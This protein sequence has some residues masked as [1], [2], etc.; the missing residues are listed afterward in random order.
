MQSYQRSLTIRPEVGQ[1]RALR[2]SPTARNFAFLV[3]ASVVHSTSFFAS[4]IH[5]VVLFPN[6]HERGL[7]GKFA[8]FVWSCPVQKRPF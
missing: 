1:N 7:P 6:L 3:S 2:A 4:V 8:H 5:S